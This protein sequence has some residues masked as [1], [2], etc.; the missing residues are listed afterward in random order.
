MFGVS[1]VVGVLFHLRKEQC[2]YR[3]YWVGNEEVSGQLTGRMG[4]LD[5]AVVVALFGGMLCW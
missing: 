1:G 3:V 4:G 2:I 5:S